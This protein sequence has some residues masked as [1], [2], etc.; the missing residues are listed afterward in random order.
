MSHSKA[1]IIA[2]IGP[3]SAKKEILLAMARAGMDIIRFNFSWADIPTRLTQLSLV[4]EVEKEIGRNIPIIADLPGP[5]VQKGRAHT[6]DSGINTCITEEDKVFVKFA[7]EQKIEW[8]ALSF[9]ASAENVVCARDII[10][11]YGGDQKIIAKI[12]RK[13]ALD[14]LDS[15]I[16]VSDAVMV[17]RGDLGAE[18]PLEEIPFAER[19]IIEK[20]KKA[21]KPVI[22]ATEMLLSMTEHD[23]PTRAELTDVTQAI[24]MGSDAVMLSEETATGKYPVEAVTMMEKLVTESEKHMVGTLDI[25]PL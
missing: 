11:E 17:A 24:L 19:L 20:C 13:V 4:R 10:R 6:Y 5:R 22:T 7:I 14:N 8:I 12:E 21:G 23:T 3:T 1:Q 15:I 16:T 18:I 2:T 25:H 9:V